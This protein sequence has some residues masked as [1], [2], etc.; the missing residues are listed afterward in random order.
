MWQAAYT[1]CAMGLV[2]LLEDWEMVLNTVKRW[3]QKADQPHGQ[4]TV[5]TAS[6]SQAPPM[7]R[8]EAVRIRDLASFGMVLQLT[9]PDGQVH[10]G[11]VIDIS[12]AGCRVA[13][14][15]GQE[16]ACSGAVLPMTLFWCR[17]GCLP[18]LGRWIALQPD[19]HGLV[20]QV[21]F[22]A[23]SLAMIQGLS[24]LLAD[25]QRWQIR[26]A[27]GENPEVEA[28]LAELYHQTRS[29]PCPCC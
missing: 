28:Q 25:M 19:C 23:L 17:T 7:E 16:M 9:L 14:A 11:E 18:L 12:L 26:T 2:G 29:P 10:D 24:R 22:C 20:G 21:Q 15:D 3:W 13:L 4:K 8:R 5:S 27:Q 6:D 1:G